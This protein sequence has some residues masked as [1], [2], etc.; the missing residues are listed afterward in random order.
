MRTAT[1]NKMN[2]S[3]SGPR[4][5]A[6]AAPHT[7]SRSQEEGSQAVS[8]ADGGSCCVIDRSGQA[9]QSAGTTAHAPRPVRDKSA[10]A[11]FFFFSRRAW[12]SL[13]RRRRPRREMQSRSASK[14]CRRDADAA[15]RERRDLGARSRSFAAAAS[16]LYAAMSR[17]GTAEANTSLRNR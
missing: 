14:E 4:Q 16:R 17:Y 7:S 15:Q 9:K 10:S 13:G 11:F 8:K 1:F 6:A 12:F 5:S 3:A 2:S